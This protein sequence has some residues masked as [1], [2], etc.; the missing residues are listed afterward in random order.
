M[1]PFGGRLS[2]GKL[3]KTSNDRGEEAVGSNVSYGV[4]FNP[5]LQHNPHVHC[6][7]MFYFSLKLNLILYILISG[8]YSV[9]DAIKMCLVSI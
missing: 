7:K 5:C 9:L 4:F 8:N 3:S 2:G 6:T 1:D